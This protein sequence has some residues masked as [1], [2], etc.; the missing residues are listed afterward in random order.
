MCTAQCKILDKIFLMNDIYTYTYAYTGRN[1]YFC[2]C[3]LLPQH[4]QKFNRRIWWGKMLELDKLLPFGKLCTRY[5]HTSLIQTVGIHT[6]AQLC[7]HTYSYTYDVYKY[8][9]MHAYICSYMYNCSVT[10]RG[11][12]NTIY[13]CWHDNR[14]IFSIFHFL[15]EILGRREV[16]WV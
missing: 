2:N 6:H 4:L 16:T 12:G 11:A 9:Y 15:T 14:F 8:I 7:T 13:W 5:V 1:M 3:T 10:S